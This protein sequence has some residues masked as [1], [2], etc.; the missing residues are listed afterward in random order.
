V[1]AALAALET[2]DKG[3]IYPQ[4]LGDLFLGH[5]GPP[6]ERAEGVPEDELVLLG[7]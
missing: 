4:P 2:A 6:A 1:C 3:G 5:P 7:G